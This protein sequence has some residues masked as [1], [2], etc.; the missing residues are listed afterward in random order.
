LTY[1]PGKRLSSGCGA[2]DD[3]G[4]DRPEVLSFRLSPAV[5]VIGGIAVAFC[6]YLVLYSSGVIP[7]RLFEKADE[8][9]LD[10]PLAL[11]TLAVG[12]LLGGY[13][14][15]SWYVVRLDISG[16]GVVYRSL[17]REKQIRWSEL[18][19]AWVGPKAADLVLRGAGSVIRVHFEWL[20]GSQT[21]KRLVLDLAKEHA[22]RAAIK[23][24]WSRHRPA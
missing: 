11:P 8:C 9:S 7:W 4:A 21:I 12:Y 18:E 10:D 19:S 16:E 1:G 14:L 24:R 22:P 20:P 23:D 17:L 6:T 15:L 3:P 2:E 5:G 13:L